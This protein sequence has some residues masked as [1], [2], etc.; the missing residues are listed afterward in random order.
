[1]TVTG[2]LRGRLSWS[3]TAVVALWVAVLTVGANVL[4]A[5][6]LDAQADDVLR[7]RAEA[8]A[9]TVQVAPDGAVTVV[10]VRDDR[11]LDVGTWIFAADGTVV[12]A[13]PGSPAEADGQAAALASQAQAEQTRDTGLPDRRG[14]NP[15]RRSAG[16]AAARCPRR[17]PPR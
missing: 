15:R 5:S 6:A 4:L 14:L 10:D 8:S 9:A 1:V 3:A 11:A 16:R 12:E 2:S 13:P 7:A 17:P